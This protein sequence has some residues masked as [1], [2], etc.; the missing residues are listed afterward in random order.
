MEQYEELIMETIEFDEE[1]VITTSNRNL[2]EGKPTSFDD[3]YIE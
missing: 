2:N 3:L 1:D